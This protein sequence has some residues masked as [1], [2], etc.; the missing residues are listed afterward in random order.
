MAA[1]VTQVMIN[2]RCIGCNAPSKPVALSA[3]S[4]VSYGQPATL[5]V[6]KGFV[7]GENG[8]VATVVGVSRMDEYIQEHD[9]NFEGSTARTRRM[10]EGL[11]TSKG[12]IVDPQETTIQLTMITHYGIL[13]DAGKFKRE[14]KKVPPSAHLFWNMFE[15]D[16]DDDLCTVTG[17]TKPLYSYSN[18][19]SIIA[20]VASN[21]VC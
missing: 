5:G 1:L 19:N 18:V 17:D 15:V 3:G 14:Y 21:E 16:S 20:A 7:Q 8:L 6:V 4:L 9:E 13:L 2:L 11:D 10:L 12:L